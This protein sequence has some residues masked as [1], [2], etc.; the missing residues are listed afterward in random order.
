MHVTKSRSGRVTTQ[1]LQVRDDSDKVLMSSLKAPGTSLK[2]SGLGEGT[3]ADAMVVL[4]LG[5]TR[6]VVLLTSLPSWME[7]LTNQ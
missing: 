2:V 5:A 4:N 1:A 6:S 7:R 3:G